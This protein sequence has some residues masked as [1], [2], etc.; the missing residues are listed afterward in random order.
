MALIRTTGNGKVDLSTLDLAT[1][2]AAAPAAAYANNV[3]LN[4]LV[5]GK[6]YLLINLGASSGQGDINFTI[7]GG[8]IINDVNNPDDSAVII[9]KANATSVTITSSVQ[10]A[11]YHYTYFVIDNA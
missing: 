11:F 6:T 8:E 3:T 5:V 10:S 7:T 9:F 2:L 4:D 1:G